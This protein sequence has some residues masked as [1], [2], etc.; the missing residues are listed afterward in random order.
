MNVKDA[1][2][3]AL[4]EMV[5]PELAVMKQEPAEIKAALV[6]TNKPLDDINSHLVDQSRRIDDTNKRIDDSNKRID[7]IHQDVIL[8]F[9]ETRK[10]IDAV[11]EELSVEIKETNKRLDRLY[12]VIVRR[13]EHQ[14]LET[15]LARLEQDKDALKRRLAA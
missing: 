2:V 13:E 14:Q 10:R 6:L 7:V 8:R 1:V 12:E 15:R 9:D 3:A 11:R 4:K 5:L